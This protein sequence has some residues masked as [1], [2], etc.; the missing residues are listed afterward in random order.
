MIK[1]WNKRLNEKGMSLK[2]KIEE[3]TIVGW[4][5]F[6]ISDTVAIEGNG[7]SSFDETTNG[8]FEPD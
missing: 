7:Q 4:N 8:N 3:G 5:F 1:G 6:H 2:S